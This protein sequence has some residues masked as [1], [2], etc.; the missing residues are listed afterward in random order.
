MFTIKIA[1][2][3]CQEWIKDLKEYVNKH[4]Q[5]LVSL[6]QRLPLEPEKVQVVIK[7]LISE[8]CKLIEVMKDCLEWFKQLDAICKQVNAEIRQGKSITLEE[9]QQMIN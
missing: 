7:E 9:F 5:E 4:S 8:L 1:R 6:R 2:S 3:T